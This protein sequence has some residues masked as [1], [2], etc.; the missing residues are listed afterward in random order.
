MPDTSLEFLKRHE[1]VRAGAGAGKTY[2]LTHKVMDIASA[3][4]AR[5]EGHWPRIVVTTF[6]R[7]ATQELRE[8]LM[9]LALEEKPELVDFVNSRSHLMVST[10]HGVMD[11]YL[12]RYGAHICIDPGY[13]VITGL[14][15]TKLARQVLRQAVLTDD[16]ALLL[17]TYPFNAL[18]TLAR[19]LE[20]AWSENADAK[21]CDLAEFERLFSE[22]AKTL[23]S[24]LM[25]SADSIRAEASKP[26]WIEMADT[27]QRIAQLLRAGNWSKNR[28][29]CLEI[30]ASMKTARMN[31]K[32]PPVSDE[33]ALEAKKIRET[34]KKLKE[35]LYDPAV[36]EHFAERFV[37]IE[38]VARK[39]SEAFRKE[40]RE[41]G[42]LEIN[43][44][45]LRAMEC[46]RAHPETALAFS[47]EWDHWLIDEYQDTS[48]FQVALL[49]KLV[50]EEPCFIVGDP[51]QSIYL[52]RGARS[53][54]FA[55]KEKEIVDAGGER[56]LLTMNRRSHPELLLF[57]NDFFSRFDPPFQP[58][59]PFIAKET[60]KDPSKIVAHVYVAS[61][62]S[63]APAPATGESSGE[64]DEDPSSDAAAADDVGKHDDEMK[65][66]VAYVQGLRSK[67]AKPED[68]CI[69]AR[70]NA[71][72]DEVSEWLAK[73]NQPAHVHA[74]AGFFDRRETRDA[75]AVMKFLANPHDAFNLVELLRSPWFRVPDRTLVEITKKKMKTQ[76]LWEMLLAQRSMAVEMEPIARLERLLEES[77]AIGISGAF[78]RALVQSGFIDLSHRHDTSGRRESNVW[79]LIARLEAEEMR[80]G[81][82]PLAF[83]TGT[84]AEL[85]IEEGGGEGDAVAAVEP[86]RINL[87][88]VHAS[89][90]LEFKHVILPRMEQ[91]P[92]LTNGEAFIFDSDKGHWAA[93]VPFGENADMTGSLVEEAH[94]E[95]FQ[96]QELHE[97]ARV[98]Y[99]ALTR[100]VESLFLTWTGPALANSWAEMSRLD[101]TPG[102]HRTE[103]YSYEVHQGPWEPQ[104]EA[105]TDEEEVQPRRK[106]KDVAVTSMGPQSL[107]STTEEAKPFSVT[108]M[109]ERKPGL[110]VSSETQRDVAIKLKTAATGTAVHKLMELLKYPSRARMDRLVS[111]WFP[112]DEARMLAAV[113]FVR[114]A[115][116]PALGEIIVNGEVEWG[117]SV[118]IERLLV[119]GQIDLWGRDDSGQLWVVDYKSGSTFYM[120]SAFKQMSIY[121][122]A[123]R[124]SGLVSESETI[125]LAA[126]YPM[127]REIFERPELSREATLAQFGIKQ[128]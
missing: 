63:A 97:H 128:S 9:L 88:T 122:L 60:E 55:K 89:K 32:N 12:K 28:A 57:F 125:K 119:D 114:T 59:E 117:F 80:P 38:R 73:Y 105:V 75:L 107:N 77:R 39:F 16:D 54:V 42:W 2:T 91:R 76:S 106:F 99:V 111:K 51:Q 40:K 1:I 48:P 71:V 123:L 4:V 68:I 56:H 8:R 58:M 31:A 17:E 84:A 67:G 116:K 109:L 102:V 121:A 30:L 62:L 46:M 43:D 44:L 66:I 23:A 104:E 81:F 90:G 120:E 25:S 37:A 112:G 101:L 47:K 86:D 70:T 92:R 79:K 6:T 7:K 118:I 3:H 110:V 29:T 27:Y 5:E 11:L 20:A 72:L 45:E 100:A 10:I 41:R 85:K 24:G 98:L 61:S 82:N 49:R 13:K 36:W 124:A 14:Q 115:K 33:T 53:D 64:E 87:M 52:F 26:D 113:E 103:N 21:P 94:K 127:T 65:A 83:V 74:A 35:P 22:K 15:A 69:L 19:R 96:I 18:T 50:G 108:E 126:V 34:V 95:A 93:R 78:K